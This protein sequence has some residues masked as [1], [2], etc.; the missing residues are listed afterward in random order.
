MATPSTLTSRSPAP[1]AA[2]AF[3]RAPGP[4]NNR[5]TNR[6][7]AWAWTRCDMRLKNIFVEGDMSYWGEQL[8]SVGLKETLMKATDAVGW[9]KPRPSPGNRSW[10]RVHFQSPTRTPT[11]SS[12]AVLVDGRGDVTVL[13]GTVEI[14]QGC[15]TI[16]SQI[17]AE[18]LKVPVEKVHMHRSTPTLSPST[19]RRLR[20]EAL[21]T[22]ET[23]SGRLPSK[24][25]IS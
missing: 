11:T 19:H 1:S 10:F 23:P 2:T 7:S 5:W 21:T 15:S 8:H 4:V 16:L 9:G 12:A 18:E 24:P 14:G 22:W 6:P 25:A 13:A 20:A 17:A 3:P